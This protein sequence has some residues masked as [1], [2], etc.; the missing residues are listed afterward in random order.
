MRPITIL[1]KMLVIVACI[2]SI[3]LI[4]GDCEEFQWMPSAYAQACP[5][6]PEELDELYL[7]CT[8]SGGSLDPETCECNG[9]SGGGGGGGGYDPC[10]NIIEYRIVYIFSIT[11][12][13]SCIGCGMVYAC[14]YG[15]MFV[16]LIGIDGG[17]CGTASA[18][19]QNLGCGT[20]DVSQYPYNDNE[21]MGTQWCG[22][23]CS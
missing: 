13:G 17:Y 23:G 12:T 16:E 3:L 4:I 9:S 5:C 21:C 6:D 2:E 7:Q 19:G 8:A 1:F 18:S 20:L 10:A 14:C 15:D 11:C 22:S